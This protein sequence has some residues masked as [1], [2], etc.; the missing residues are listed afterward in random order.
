MLWYM[1]KK[2]LCYTEMTP[3]FLTVFENTY[4]RSTYTPISST[5]KGKSDSL[6]GRCR[7]RF[8][9]WC[10]G[11]VHHTSRQQQKQVMPNNV[12]TS[13]KDYK[14]MTPPVQMR[15]RMQ[16]VPIALLLC[17]STTAESQIDSPCSLL[18]VG[19]EQTIMQR[20]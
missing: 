14:C 15:Y 3:M 9:T 1:V 8:K 11:P 16:L 12:P 18:N 4:R 2:A 7:L 6:D 13:R 5:E 19:Q 20:N 10:L 17:L